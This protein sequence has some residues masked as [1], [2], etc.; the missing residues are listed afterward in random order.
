MGARIM[1]LGE[2]REAKGWTQLRLADELECTVSTIW[3]Y[4]QGLRDPDGAT[5]E[6]IFVVSD[7]A[8]EPNDFYDVPRWRRALAAAVALLSGKAA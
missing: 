7:G 6:R 8:V 5:K 4:E 3:R 2:W 1:K